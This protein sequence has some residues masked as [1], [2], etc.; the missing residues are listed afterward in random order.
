MITVNLSITEASVF[1]NNINVPDLPGR[2]RNRFHLE[3]RNSA[4]TLRIVCELNK[5]NKIA[6]PAKESHTVIP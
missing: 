4:S 6:G 1:Q 5:K 2:Q 3:H